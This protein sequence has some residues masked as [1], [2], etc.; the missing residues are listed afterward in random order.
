MDEGKVDLVRFCTELCR[1]GYDAR[2]V[3]NA[4]SLARHSAGGGE[5]G[6]PAPNALEKLRHSHVLVTGLSGWEQEM[7]DHQSEAS[8]FP[9]L[10]IVDPLFKEQF[11][12][13]HP[14]RA[15]ASL[16][17]ALPDEFVGSPD[18]LHAVVHLLCGEV[19]AAF[20]CQGQPLPP[21]RTLRSTLGKWFDLGPATQ[22]VA[23]TGDAT[24]QGAVPAVEGPAGDAP[25]AAHRRK[26]SLTQELD[27]SRPA[28]CDEDDEGCGSTGQ[29][30]TASW[31]SVGVSADLA[32]AM[33]GLLTETYVGGD[34]VSKVNAP[35]LR[36]LQ[37]PEGCSRL[38][39]SALV[40]EPLR[41]NNPNPEENTERGLPRHSRAPRRVRPHNGEIQ[42]PK[43]VS[44]V[45]FDERLAMENMQSAELSS[46]LSSGRA[47]ELSGGV[48]AKDDDDDGQDLA[49]DHKR[50]LLAERLE[51]ERSQGWERLLPAVITVR[52]KG[53]KK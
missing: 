27:D 53:K 36:G 29:S 21:W 40:S 46:R 49:T 35:P 13:G 17:A 32:G 5:G 11:Q 48:T 14:S 24:P 3:H 10:I 38:A 6:P 16:L 42:A 34:D 7:A 15:Y 4:A 33:S 41:D 44:T 50:S 2:V 37:R 31:A 25:P 52:L 51:D 23:A 12:L 19:A 1:L 26:S 39:P 28:D 9:T 18:R 47:S 20:V 43:Q 30:V 8:P 22:A 45:G